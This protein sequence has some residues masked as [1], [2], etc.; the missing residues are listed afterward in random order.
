[1]S[2]KGKTVELNPDDEVAELKRRNEELAAEIERLK[3]EPSV[4]DFLKEVTARLGWDMSEKHGVS[5]LGA[6]DIMVFSCAFLRHDGHRDCRSSNLLSA[7]N[8]RRDA[9]IQAV[10]AVR[11]RVSG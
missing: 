9:F 8:A 7:Y 4:T 6:P 1:M 11:D 3:S 5:Q 10:V 2:T